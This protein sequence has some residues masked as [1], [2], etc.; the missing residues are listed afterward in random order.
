[1][2]APAARPHLPALAGAALLALAQAG[3]TLAEPWPLAL[4]VDHALHHAPF[5]AALATLNG[6]SPIALLILAGVTLIVLNAVIGLLGMAGT[7]L[8]ERAA[9]HI[10]ATLRQD[11]FDRAMTLSLRWHDHMRSGELS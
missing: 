3:I 11:L 10:G 7:L 6:L 8:G 5:T 1:V 9:E 4:A 2:A